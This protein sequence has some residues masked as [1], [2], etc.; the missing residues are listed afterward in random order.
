VPTPSF[1]GN[2][3]ER[4]PKLLATITPSFHLP[5]ELGEIYGRYKRVGNIFADAGNGLALPGYGVTSLGAILNVSERVQVTFN[6][7]NVFGV[8]GVTEGNP[9]Q[10]QT[11]SLSSGLFYGRGIV[12]TTYYGSVTLR[13]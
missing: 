11:Q 3:P 4:T 10:G 12:G 7:D 5:N 1:D 13:F 9:R 6:A 2:R 8:T